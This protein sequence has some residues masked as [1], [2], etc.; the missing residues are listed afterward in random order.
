MEIRKL[1]SSQI[2]LLNF[3]FSVSNSEVWLLSMCLS[4]KGHQHLL[5]IHKRFPNFQIKMNQV[6]NQ[7]KQTMKQAKVSLCFSSHWLSSQKSS[8]ALHQLL[9]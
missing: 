5:L 9:R 1:N 6:I 2:L 3:F 7:P 8:A 4:L